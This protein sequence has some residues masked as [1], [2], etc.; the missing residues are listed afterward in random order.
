MV[1]ADAVATMM[2]KMI[3]RLT[4]TT[5]TATARWAAPAIFY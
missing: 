3:M 1:E 5:K 2:T 4:A